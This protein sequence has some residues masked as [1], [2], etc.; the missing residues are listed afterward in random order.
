MGMWLFKQNI[1][2][3]R[4]DIS[5]LVSIGLGFSNSSDVCSILKMP[6]KI[7]NSDLSTEFGVLSSIF[8]DDSSPA[9][10]GWYAD[11]NNKG[12]WDGNAIS[13]FGACNAFS[14]ILDSVSG[15]CVSF[16]TSG[17]DQAS[18]G[19]EYSIDN[20]VTWTNSNGSFVSPRCGFPAPTVPTKYRIS[21]VEQPIVYSNIIEIFPTMTSYNYTSFYERNDPAHPNGGTFSYVDINGTVVN[22]TLLWSDTCFQFESQVVP[23]NI[24]GIDTNTC[25]GEA[26][27]VTPAGVSYELSN[28]MQADAPYSY[29]VPGG[30]VLTNTFLGGYEVAI[31]CAVSGSVSADSAI[32]ITDR[33]AC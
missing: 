19:V 23:Y 18:V 29:M 30:T 33:G 2:K 6:Y 7:S 21:S 26:P 32:L 22:K 15:G 12:Y 4:R 28:G 11:W 8:N 5:G 10:I 1:Y 3:N 9:A 14:I 31:I 24:V 27:S 20:G 16:T 25:V 17:P 13:M